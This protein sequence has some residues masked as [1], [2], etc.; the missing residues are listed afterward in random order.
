MFE[1]RTTLRTL[2]PDDERESCPKESYPLYYLG[3]GE[4]NPVNSVTFCPF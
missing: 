1:V 3:F 2:I 4:I